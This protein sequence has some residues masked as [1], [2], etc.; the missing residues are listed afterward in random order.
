MHSQAHKGSHTLDLVLFALSRC[1]PQRPVLSEGLSYLLGLSAPF[2]K[3]KKR[4]GVLMWEL[5]VLKKAL[6]KKK[7][8]RFNNNNVINLHSHRTGPSYAENGTVCLSQCLM[9]NK[10]QKK[11]KIK[12]TQMHPSLVTMS[13]YCWTGRTLLHPA[14]ISDK[15][16][17]MFA[18]GKVYSR[19]EGSVQSE[20][21]KK[22]GGCLRNVRRTTT[23]LYSAPWLLFCNEAGNV[24]AVCSCVCTPCLL[25]SSGSLGLCS[26][27]DLVSRYFWLVAV[28][29][30]YRPSAEGSLLLEPDWAR[31]MYRFNSFSCKQEIEQKKKHDNINLKCLQSDVIEMRLELT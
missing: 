12:T 29:W 19:C 9:K 10:P 14:V 6:Q 17:R 15:H 1:D 7:S 13:E 28:L 16:G 25:C 26:G 23:F 31:L 5:L 22:K 27:R 24:S 4:R 30:F 2:F 8:N 20:T 3:E 18:A 21:N 11:I